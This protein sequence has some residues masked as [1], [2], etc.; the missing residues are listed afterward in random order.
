MKCRSISLALHA[1][2]RFVIFGS[3]W[4]SVYFYFLDLLNNI[5]E[6]EQLNSIFIY[7]CLQICTVYLAYFRFFRTDEIF[8]F[9]S[10]STN[11]AW[12]LPQP[13]N[14]T[15]PFQFSIFIFPTRFSLHLLVTACCYTHSQHMIRNSITRNEHNEIASCEIERERRTRKTKKRLEVRRAFA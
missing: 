5:I 8:R 10:R 7:S 11:C 15:L 1:I 3:C 6:H 13:I 14:S 2:A 4:G 9:L 12:Y